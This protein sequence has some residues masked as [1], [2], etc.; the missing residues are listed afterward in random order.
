MDINCCVS[1]PKNSSV[2]SLSRITTLVAFYEEE[3]GIC[4]HIT[5]HVITSYACHFV[6][7]DDMDEFWGEETQQFMFILRLAALFV[8]ENRQMETKH[9]LVDIQNYRIP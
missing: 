8:E 7:R 6:I 1:S 5:Y 2:S 3:A 4:Q 9:S